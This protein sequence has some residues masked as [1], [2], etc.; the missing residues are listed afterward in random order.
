MSLGFELVGVNERAGVE[1]PGMENSASGS[2]SGPD[3]WVVAGRIGMRERANNRRESSLAGG[4]D[5]R[6][7][8]QVNDSARVV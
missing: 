3:V 2:P 5:I 4:R 7:N 6:A 8:F 1:I